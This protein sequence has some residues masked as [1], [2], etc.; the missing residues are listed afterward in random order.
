MLRA[1]SEPV[2]FF[3]A[4]AAFFAVL[5][6]GF[7][8]GRW[9]SP[10]SDEG[11]KSHVNALQAPLLALMALLL[12][13]NFAMAGSRFDTRKALIQEEVDA[14]N[15][16]Y[17]RSQFLPTPYREEIINLLKSYLTARIDF[18]RA[19]VDPDL[20]ATANSKALSLERQIWAHTTAMMAQD[21]NGASKTMFIQT[22]NDMINVQERRS[23]ALDN[24]VPEIVIHLLFTVALGALGFIGFGYGLTGHRRHGTTAIFALL[25]AMVLTTIIDLDQPRT[26]LIRVTDDNILRLKTRLD[27]NN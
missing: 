3:C 22:L 24:H 27:Q 12:G 8:L 1:F 18:M 20:I 25:V 5:E 4:L 13:F 17:L 14:I 16:T 21:P 2:L 11:V 9:Y 26:G 10:H 6:I 7:R 19:G 23:A 15:T